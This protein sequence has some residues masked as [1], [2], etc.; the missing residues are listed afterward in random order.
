MP[1]TTGRKIPK[2]PHADYSLT[3]QLTDMQ[4]STSRINQICLEVVNSKEL[5]WS[6]SKFFFHDLYITGCRPSE[7]LQINK[8]TRVG[9]TLELITAK[10]EAKRKF[11]VEWLSHNLI[12]AIIEDKHP[13]DALTYDQL[14]L[15]FRKVTT[16][17]PIWIGKKCVD[18][19]LFRYN[20]ARQMFEERKNVVEVMNFFGWLSDKV[21]YG[22]IHQPLI[23]NG[24]FR[25]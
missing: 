4:L 19:Y 10:T 20:R 23:F 7:L 12:E 15:E 5:Y 18:T 17:H 3:H 8:W 21:A 9:D 11:R 2:T 1:N 13:Y 25:L 24:T 16:L 14:T 6:A 22:Y